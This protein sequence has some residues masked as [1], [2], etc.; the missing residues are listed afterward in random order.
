MPQAS[1]FLWN[2]RMLLQLNCRGYATAQFMQPEPARYAHAPTLE[3]KSFMQPEQP[4]YA[5]HPGRFCYVKDE[6]GGLL[7]SAP[8]APVNR[9]PDAFAF[10]V[11]QGDV[12]WTV[13]CDGIEVE[14][15][16]RLPL[17]DVAELW[18]VR[19]R[20]RSGRAAPDQPVSVLPG[21]LHV[22]DEP[23]R[24]LSRRPGRDRL[25][26]RHPVPEGGRPFPPARLQGPHRAAARAPARCL[27]SEPGRV[28]GRGRIARAGRRHRA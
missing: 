1:T 3:A 13:Q 9:A 4:Y 5:H 22:V 6:D 7:F 19:V 16:V 2:R 11:G 25:R 26:Q 23:V 12:A 24:P 17:E 27:G 21:R 14:M 15:S 8:H 20:N 10:S 18:T 28:R